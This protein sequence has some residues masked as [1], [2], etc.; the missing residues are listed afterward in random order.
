[1]TDAAEPAPRGPLELRAVA[2][3]LQFLTV[4]PPL[5]R[6]ALLPQELGHAVAYYPLVGLLLG[7]VLAVLHWGL[8]HVLPAGL[9]SALVLAAWVWA[10]GALHLDGFLDSCDGLFGGFTPE[11]RL[12]IMRDERVGAFAV[13]GGVLLLLVKY[14][15]LAATPHPLA[16]LVLA[17]VLGRWTIAGA[18]V[19]FPYARAKGLGRDIKDHARGTQ[20]LL[21]S[22]TAVAVS[23]AWGGIV[24]GLLAGA[25]AVLVL[26]LGGRFVLARLPGMTGDTY[27][28]L[29]EASE[30]A[31]LIALC[32]TLGASV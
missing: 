15:A 30:T 5:L 11:D 10:S 22:V 18:V 12:R 7:G 2:T 21:A 1:M 31:V 8:S 26:L 3:A 9:V 29:C 24:P 6:R 20:W 25:A 4:A 27:G 14:A 28:A 32:L 19:A 17:P 13:V 16:A 23:I